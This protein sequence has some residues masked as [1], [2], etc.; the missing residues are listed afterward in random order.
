[1]RKWRGLRVVSG[2]FPKENA[3]FNPK[4]EVSGKGKGT[5]KLGSRVAGKGGGT[6]NLKSRVSAGGKGALNVGSGISA[7]GGGA[8]NLGSLVCGKGNGAL[9]FGSGLRVGIKL[10][11]NPHR[12]VPAKEKLTSK[13]ESAT[14]EVRNAVPISPQEFHWLTASVDRD[15]DDGCQRFC[16][17]TA[18]FRKASFNAKAQR[19]QRGAETGLFLWA[20]RSSLL[21]APLRPLR[22]CVAM[23]SGEWNFPLRASAPC[24]NLR[25]A[26]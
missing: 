8:F 9:N 2:V 16:S 20:L 26:L 17:A 11:C 12:G 14:G 13:M 18:G 10:P 24:P 25:P 21:C 22:L 1:M 15:A 23:A 5:F 3:I 6:S 7:K 4:S 19:P